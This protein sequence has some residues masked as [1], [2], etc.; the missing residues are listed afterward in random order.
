MPAAQL[1]LA[2]WLG[3]SGRTGEAREQLTALR[4]EFS[5][6]TVAI[7]EGFVL[8]GLAW[9]DNQDG[10]YAD[11]LPRGLEA[12]TLS[13]DRLS[14]MVAPQMSVIHLVTIARALGGLG[15]ERRAVLAAR[16]LGAYKGLLPKGHVQTSMERQDYAQA[17]ELA[18][19]VLGRAA[20]DAAYAEG[21]GL[22]LEEATA[23]VDA[24]RD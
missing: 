6:R 11:A 22:S 9:L 3:R 12:L 13:R 18:V 23:L 5:S 14:Q 4:E 20:Y 10:L 21:G 15:G 1:F 17:E 19:A 2:M 8:G 7:F 16:L 24:H